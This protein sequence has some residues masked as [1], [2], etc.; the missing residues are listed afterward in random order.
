MR[1]RREEAE[2]NEESKL[3]QRR[4]SVMGR[5]H[6]NRFEL[7]AEVPMAGSE[8]T[9]Q[10]P[11]LQ[12]GYVDGKTQVRI[13]G[14]DLRGFGDVVG[15]RR[16]KA[17]LQGVG[18]YDEY[19]CRLAATIEVPKEPGR[20]SKIIPAVRFAFSSLGLGTPSKPIY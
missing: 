18:V 10:T 3:K 13:A 9:A 1:E 20:F 8:H 11:M 6:S 5:A 16:Y 7:F 14:L 12:A 15:P 17:Y 2:E 4:N 19:A